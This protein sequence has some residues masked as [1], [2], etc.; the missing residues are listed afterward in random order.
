MDNLTVEGSVGELSVICW[1]DEVY[2]LEGQVGAYYRVNESL[3]TRVE[4]SFIHRSL[5]RMTSY[6]KNPIFF[7]TREDFVSSFLLNTWGAIGLFSATVRV[8][9]L[10]LI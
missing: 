2:L 4:M 10:V 8:I 9:L 1:A 6:L 7:F 5:N 3:V